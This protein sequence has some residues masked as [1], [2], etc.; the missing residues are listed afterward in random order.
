MSVLTRPRGSDLGAEGSLD[1]DWNTVQAY[2]LYDTGSLNNWQVW[3]YLGEGTLEL[4]EAS[5]SFG[6]DVRGSS[7]VRVYGG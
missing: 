4:E 7:V 2:L 1:V 5:T 3:A 6:E